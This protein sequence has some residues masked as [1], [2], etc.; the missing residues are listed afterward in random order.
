MSKLPQYEAGK[1]YNISPQGL[2]QI[3]QRQRSSKYPG[4]DVI[5]TDD[6]RVELP[7]RLGTSGLASL[8]PRTIIDE[9]ALALEKYG[10]NPALSVKRNNKWVTLTYEDFY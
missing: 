2:D 9:W 8:P 3:L 5:W 6:I 10:K 4:Q 7:I 1:V